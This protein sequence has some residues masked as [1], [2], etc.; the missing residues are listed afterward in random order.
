VHDLG[1]CTTMF[2]RYRE[3]MAALREPAISDDIRRW[4]R[5]WM[6]GQEDARIY[7]LVR[8]T[9]LDRGRVHSGGNHPDASGRE[10]H[11]SS[12]P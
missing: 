12:Y 10:L 6:A 8:H 11:G 7:D 4:P 1:N 3:V 5:R 2:S 9:P